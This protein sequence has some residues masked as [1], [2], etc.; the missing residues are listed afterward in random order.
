MLTGLS[1]SIFHCV[2]STWTRFLFSSQAEPTLRYKPT[3]RYMLQSVFPLLISYLFEEEKVPVFLSSSTFLAEHAAELQSI[4]ADFH[5]L[6][7]YLFSLS[8]NSRTFLTSWITPTRTPFLPEKTSVCLGIALLYIL[9]DE[10][11]TFSLS[12]PN[13]FFHFFLNKKRYT[14]PWLTSASTVVSSLCFAPSAV[15]STP[16]KRSFSTK[17]GSTQSLVLLHLDISK[18]LVVGNRALALLTF[19]ITS[20]SVTCL[21]EIY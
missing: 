2:S 9:F 16:L 20:T 4:R 6:Q 10:Y 5:T 18:F 11:L 3:L 1:I 14:C 19:G 12:F 7:D 8:V 21:M 13:S 15:T 17:Q